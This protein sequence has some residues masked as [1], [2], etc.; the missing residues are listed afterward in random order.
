MIKESTFTQTLF[1]PTR[2]GIVE[3]NIR[4]FIVEDFTSYL[5]FFTER[6]YKAWSFTQPTTVKYSAFKIYPSYYK[7][8]G[9][10]LSLSYDV[11]K[12]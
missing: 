6:S 8:A 10:H 9:L 4:D 3:G 2:T 11:D 7:I 5:Q 12:I 1:D